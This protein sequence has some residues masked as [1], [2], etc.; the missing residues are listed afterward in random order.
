MTS[1]TSL[2]LPCARL[3]LAPSQTDRWLRLLSAKHLKDT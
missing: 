3:P 1:V 2:Q